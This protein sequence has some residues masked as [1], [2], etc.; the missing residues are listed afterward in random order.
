MGK[1]LDYS[2]KWRVRA[3]LNKCAVLICNEDEE[4]QVEFKCKRVEEELPFVDQ[5]SYIG[6]EILNNCSW[7]ARIGKVVEKGEA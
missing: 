7:N 5:C 1:A 2:R 3:N 4:N 6:V